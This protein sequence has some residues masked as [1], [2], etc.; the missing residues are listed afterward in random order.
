MN[1][2]ARPDR[3]LRG[4]IIRVDDTVVGFLVQGKLYS[5]HEN[6][7]ELVNNEI[8]PKYTLKTQLTIIRRVFEDNYSLTSNYNGDIVVHQEANGSIH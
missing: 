3:N 4:H 7:A 5:E 8:K 1:F 2:I 6:F